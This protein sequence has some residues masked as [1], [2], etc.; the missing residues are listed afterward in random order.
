VSFAGWLQE[1]RRSVLFLVAALAAGGVASLSGLSVGLFPRTTFPRLVVSVDAGDRPADRMVVEV[2]R[3]LEE[4]VR[5]VPG[6]RNV[7]S[8]TSRGSADISV[9]FDWGVDMISA[10]LQA[11]SEIARSLPDLPPGVRYEVRRMDPTVFPVIGLSLRSSGHSLVELRDIALYD[12]QPLLSTIDGVARIAVLGGRTAELQ[13]RLD[14]VRLAAAGVTLE[15]VVK[16]VSAANVVEAVGRLE[17]DEKLYLVLSDTQFR[18]LDAISKVIVR[19]SPKG[20]VLLED[21]ATVERSTAPE[22]TRVV[23]DGGEAVLLNVYQQPGGDTV[24]IAA[25]LDARLAEFRARAPAGLTIQAWYDQS[26]LIR[27]AASSVRDA[28]AIGIAL[29]VLVLW[30]F[31][32]NVRVTLVATLTVPVVL[33]ATLLILRALDKSLNIMTLGGMAAAVGL[34]ID[35]GI[36]MVEHVLRRLREHPAERHLV[37]LRAAREMA[38]PLTGSSLATVVIFLPLAWLSGVTG[39]FF[40]ALSL[41]MASALIVSY[42]VAFLAVPLLADLLLRPRDAEVEDVGPFYG[43]VLDAYERA[44]RALLARPVWVLPLLAVPAALGL[45]AW[46]EVRTGFMPAMDEGGFVLDYVA[47]AGTSLDETDRRLREVE[48]I[49]GSVPEVRSYSRRTGLALGGFI[50]EPNEG[51]YFVRLTPLPRRPIDEIMDEVRG[52]IEHEV[53]GLEVELA[54]LME[55]LIGDLTAVPQPVEVKLFG[56]DPDALRAS[57]ASVASAIAETPGVVDVKSGVVL[58]GDAVDIRVDRVRA[59]LLGLDPDSVTRFALLALE[60]NVTTEVQRGEKMV[61]VRVWTEAEQRDRLDRVRRLLLRTEDGRDVRLGRVASFEKVVGQPQI[62]RENL[63]TMVAVTGRISGRDLGSV[64]RDVKATVARVQLPAGA[65]VAYGGLYR[66]QQRSFR[67]LVGV[68]LAAVILVFV[69]LLY[70]YE[71]FAAPLAVLIVDAMAATAVFVGLWWTGTELDIS[72]M[73]GLTMIVGISSEAAVFYLSQWK[74]SRQEMPFQEA[75]VSAGRLRLRPI[76]MTALAAIGAL[77]PLALALGAGAAMLQPLAIAIVAGL[78]ATVPGVLLVLP[79][80]FSG[81]AGASGQ[82]G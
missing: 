61:G 6:V 50:T 77:V 32:R 25:D 26:D 39:A 22:W 2:T 45:L 14:P 9:D 80:V 79:A 63:K 40:R 71:R 59:R 42:F 51:D 11:Q 5:G 1:H 16:A 37:V 24:Q 36:V 10:T 29:A 15:E 52:R 66:E 60:G 82:E 81:L 69:L 78:T 58:A 33:A 55:D 30:T 74:E 35:D 31:L 67:D 64:M 3:P 68:L 28:V 44:L 27:D 75:L 23:A 17:E 73:M 12:L 43:R 57:A 48:R 34:V 19:E 53:P 76:L 56:A 4:A 49:L 18:D 46:R 54:L 62:A 38:V 47:P 21:V 13:V 41:T 65:Y 72:S 70:L 7:R 8:N 20:F